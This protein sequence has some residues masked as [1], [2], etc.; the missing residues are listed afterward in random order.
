MHG[1]NREAFYETL[2][3]HTRPNRG[4]CLSE[5]RKYIFLLEG[6]SSDIVCNVASLATS[7]H[8]KCTNPYLD[9]SSYKVGI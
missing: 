4:L 1:V 7:T 3:S 8:R 6:V 2:P 9:I 5:I